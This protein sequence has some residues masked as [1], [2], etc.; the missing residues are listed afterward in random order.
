MVKVQRGTLLSSDE[1]TIT[2]LILLDEKSVGLNKFIVAK[3]DSRNLMIKT[4]RL[5]AV[6]QA[7]A[8]RLASTM[9]DED[10]AAGN[11]LAPPQG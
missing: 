3:L 4:D 11:P 5:V 6:K 2:F 8:E 1:A 9:W 7:I 10:E